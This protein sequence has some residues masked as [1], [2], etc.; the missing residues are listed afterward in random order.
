MIGLRNLICIDSLK[1]LFIYMNAPWCGHCKSLAPEYAKAATL[2]AEEQSEIM[3]AKVDATKESKVARK[4]DIQG[5]PTLKLFKGS[6]IIDYTGGRKAEEIIQ[7]LK[8]KTGPPA[9]ELSTAEDATLFKESAHVVVVGFFQDQEADDAK[10]FLEVADEIDDYPFAITSSKKVYKQLD[11]ES[12]G[13]VLFK[14]FDEGRNA[15]EDEITI[16]SLKKFVKANSLPLVIEFDSENAQKIFD[17]DIKTHI[18]LFISKSS[19]EYTKLVEDYNSAA[20]VYKKKVKFVVVDTEKEDHERIVEFFGLKK[21]DMPAVQI[22]QLKDDVKK[23]KPETKEISLKTI[24]SFLEGVFDGRL[25]EHLL[26]EDVPEDWDKHPVKVLVSK[27]FESVAFDKSKDVLV[28]FFA[29]WCGHCQ[30]LAPIYGELGEKYKENDAIVIAKMDST[31]NELE[32][33]KISSFPTI[34][35]YK[36]GTNEA[37]EYNG[38]LTLDGITK[39]LE[40]NGEYGKDAP[41]KDKKDDEPD[42][43]QEKDEL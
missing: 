8:K 26:S 38:E 14:K 4:Y 12:D 7:W 24:H 34:K 30:H 41:N 13:V 20:G 35:L 39:F 25:K 10:V 18:F 31:R 15:F 42:Y 1:D 3:L 17:G 9:K 21:E 37:I 28:E 29:P 5:Y 6:K 16:K 43:V 33:T 27:N 32:H 19:P 40:T 36:K 11:V 2:L 22:I 23:F